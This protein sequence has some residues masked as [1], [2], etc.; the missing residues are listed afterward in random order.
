MTSIEITRPDPETG[1]TR[2]VVDGADLSTAL[3]GLEVEFNGSG[4][5]RVTLRAEYVQEFR[6]CSDVAE[7]IIDERILDILREQGWHD[8]G[9]CDD[10]YSG[11]PIKFPDVRIGDGEPGVT[12]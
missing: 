1:G 2:V 4:N 12:A 6:L 8:P 7:V 10:G 5:P 3:T 11:P 9:G